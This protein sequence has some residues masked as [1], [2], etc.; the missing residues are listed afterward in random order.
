M[1]SAETDGEAL[2]GLFDALFGSKKRTNVEIVPDHIWMTTDAKFAGLATEAGERSRSATVAIL[3]VAHFP[4]VLARL[5]ELSNHQTWSVPCMAVLASHLNADLATSLSLDE[6]AMIDVI[7]GE[8]HPLPS[9]DDR[10]EAFADELPCR[11][12]FSHHLSLEDAVIEVFAGDW[13]KSVLTK[14]GMNEDEAIKSQMVSRRIRQKQQK[15]EG[16]AFGTVDA[17]SAAAWLEKNCPE[18]RNT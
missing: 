4:D 16:R 11:C 17:E 5:E 1:R 3:L 2:M 12:R 10:L 18:L 9:V 13:I 14:L 8:R 7:V 6:S 15:I